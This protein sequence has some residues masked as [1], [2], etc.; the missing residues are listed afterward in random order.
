[1]GCLVIQYRHRRTEYSW[2]FFILNT[3]YYLSIH[4]KEYSGVD[5][6]CQVPV[7]QRMCWIQRLLGIKASCS[8]P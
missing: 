1:M 8:T 7:G 5:N 3:E 6:V 4:M 2:P